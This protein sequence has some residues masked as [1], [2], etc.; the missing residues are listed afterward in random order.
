MIRVL[1]TDEAGILEKMAFSSQ[2]DL[3][4][5]AVEHGLV[6]GAS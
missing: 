3:V 2:A 4:R 6:D 1:L 5:Y